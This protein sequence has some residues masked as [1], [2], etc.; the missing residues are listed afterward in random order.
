MTPS[1]HL[2]YID[3]YNIVRG[4]ANNTLNFASGPV[5]PSDLHLSLVLGPGGIELRMIRHTKRYSIIS[6]LA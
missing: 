1:V 6:F 5:I 4:F 3:R 2:L